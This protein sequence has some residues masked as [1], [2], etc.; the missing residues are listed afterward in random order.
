MSAT[1]N[2]PS[3]LSETIIAGTTVQLYANAIDNHAYLVPAAN[4]LSKVVLC[5]HLGDAYERVAA[6]VG[7]FMS[8]WN[9]FCARES[10]STTR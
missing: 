9:L 1:A 8:V 7:T 3:A 10:S 2:F 4:A 6:S 5:W